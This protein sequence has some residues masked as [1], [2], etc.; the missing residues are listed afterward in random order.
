MT[1]RT[2][3]EFLKSPWTYIC[4][5]VALSALVGGFMYRTSQLSKVAAQEASA[6][7]TPDMV[8]YTNV[9]D[10]DVVRDL[11]PPTVEIIREPSGSG[12]SE[13][14]AEYLAAEPGS[15][16]YLYKADQVIH[17]PSDVEVK[18][19]I[20]FGYCADFSNCPIAPAHILSRGEA[21]ILI[22]DDGTV[23]P[24][25][26]ETDDLEAFPFLDGQKIKMVKGP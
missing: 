5:F 23:F 9:E 7:P 14:R 19:T 18:E 4:L 25:N 2:L 8:N 21:T 13:A 20:M 12:I 11:G 1:L 3:G 15:A 10:A 16:L 6:V 17:L 24:G 22:D 26:L